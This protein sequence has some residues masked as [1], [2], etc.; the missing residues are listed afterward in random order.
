MSLEKI[1][2]VKVIQER[3]YI[4]CK[5]AWKCCIFIGLQ[6]RNILVCHPLERVIICLS[7]NWIH[8]IDCTRYEI[9]C[10]FDEI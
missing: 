2:K 1:Q 5:F 9:M 4:L 8:L 3:C 7:L 10:V 6:E